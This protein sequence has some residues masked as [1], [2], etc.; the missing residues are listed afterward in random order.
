M[1]YALI[2]SSLLAV[3]A[4]HATYSQDVNGKAIA[5]KG[6]HGQTIIKINAAR[7]EIAITSAMNAAHPEVFPVTAKNSDGDTYVSYVGGNRAVTLS[8]DDQGD[9]VTYGDQ[10]EES[11]TVSVKC[12]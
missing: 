7:T 3:S 1:K 9:T 4:A 5:C 12:N 2:F 8:F 6:D 11:A 10:G